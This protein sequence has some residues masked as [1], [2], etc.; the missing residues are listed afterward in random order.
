VSP[1]LSRDPALPGTSDLDPRQVSR[2]F[3]KGLRVVETLA[4]S[5]EPLTAQ[6]IARKIGTDRAIVYRMLRTLS[7]HGLLSEGPC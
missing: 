3:S 2:T 4:Q 5:E 1:E 6:E 7:L